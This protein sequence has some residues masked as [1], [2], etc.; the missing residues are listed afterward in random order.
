MKSSKITK[1]LGTAAAML[2]LSSAASA[3]NFDFRQAFGGYY[4]SIDF[5]SDGITVTVTAAGGS[6]K[7]SVV[8]DGLGNGSNGFNYLLANN[9]QLIFTFSEEVT[10]GSITASADFSSGDFNLTY[11]G[12]TISN[13]P[14]PID[15]PPSFNAT[16][17]LN[18]TTTSFTITGT[19]NYALIEGLGDVFTT[20]SA[21]PVP[22]AAWLFGSALV[23]LAG[24]GRR[25]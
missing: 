21:V 8:D 7:V 25:K 18:I 15:S 14:A 10:V 19:D 22:A 20:A 13:I 24:L 11:E 5:I 3:A 4:N 2:L 6:N 1:T 23:G 12:G 17:L 16:T 9:E